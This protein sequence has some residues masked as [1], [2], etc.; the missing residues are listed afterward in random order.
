MNLIISIKIK[1][2]HV[3]E[4]M[5]TFRNL[6]VRNNHTCTTAALF[7]FAETLGTIYTFR[8]Y[9]LARSQYIGTM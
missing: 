5:T 9:K 3:P 4:Q 1:S 6:S 2:M 8:N 7:I